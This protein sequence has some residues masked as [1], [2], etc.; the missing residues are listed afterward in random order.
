MPDRMVSPELTWAWQQVAGA[1]DAVA[2]GSLA[3]QIGW[4]RQHLTRRFTS[5]FGLSPKLA[6]RI[7]RFER[8]KQMLANTPTF[9]SIAQIA[10]ACGYYDQPH[11]NR[12]FAQLAGCS[13]TQWLADEQLPSVQDPG[14]PGGQR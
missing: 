3:E 11:L 1:T 10:A 14:E 4:S 7:A 8:A 13:P 2:V 5:E 12:D 6:A 9:V